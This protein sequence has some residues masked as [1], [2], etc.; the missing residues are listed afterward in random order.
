[1]EH[2]LT[3]LNENYDAAIFL[4]ENRKEIVEDLLRAK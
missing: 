3:L 1:M 2:F 4:I